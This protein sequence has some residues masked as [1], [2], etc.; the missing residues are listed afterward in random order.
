[1]STESKGTITAN[2]G[3]GALVTRYGYNKGG[4]ANSDKTG[5][6]SVTGTWSGT[7]ELQ[8]AD[9]GVAADDA[10]EWVTEES[11]TANSSGVFEA[12][13]PCQI[14]LKATAWTSGTAKCLISFR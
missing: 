3:I 12:G 11:F 4:A 5:R 2:A 6:V 7:V 8:V 9:L 1:M 13:G 10:D 14:R